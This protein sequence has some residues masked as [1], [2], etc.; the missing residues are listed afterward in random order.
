MTVPMK[1]CDQQL[2]FFRWTT[3]MCLAGVQSVVLYVKNDKDIYT[4]TYT[5]LY[6]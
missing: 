6:E 3:V 4:A 5:K 1:A 2:F